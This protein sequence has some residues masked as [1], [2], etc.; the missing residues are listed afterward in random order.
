[1]DPTPSSDLVQNR[2]NDQQPVDRTAPT[3]K[4]TGKRYTLFPPIECAAQY[5]AWNQGRWSNWQHRC[6]IANVR[7]TTIYIFLPI[8]AHV[9]H[10]A[11]LKGESGTICTMGRVGT[12]EL[13]AI[14]RRRTNVSV[15]GRNVGMV[16]C[17]IDQSCIEPVEW[18]ENDEVTH[19]IVDQTV[20][21]WTTLT[22]NLATRSYCEITYYGEN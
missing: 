22:T 6:T 10:C 4:E 5:Y 2:Q 18:V 8:Q 7:T 12:L 9:P 20:D 1:M 19:K 3:M 14:L 11:A 15:S 21:T 17:S 13:N 16:G